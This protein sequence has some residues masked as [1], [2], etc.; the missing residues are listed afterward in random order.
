MRAPASSHDGALWPSVRA[1]ETAHIRASL[2]HFAPRDDPPMARRSGRP[3]S[4]TGGQKLAGSLG[5]G[6]IAKA[7]SDASLQS[8]SASHASAP[9]SKRPSRTSTR[10][11]DGTTTMIC[12]SWPCAENASRMRWSVI[13]ERVG[14]PAPVRRRQP[15]M[16]AVDVGVLRRPRRAREI[17][18][19]FRQHARAVPH[20]VAQIEIA[21]AREIAR[22]RPDQRAAVERPCGSNSTTGCMPMRIEQRLRSS[23]R[24]CG[25]G[26]RWRR[27]DRARSRASAR[28]R[29]RIVPAEL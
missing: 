14:R 21:E 26:D 25:C 9:P 17:D 15:P 22:R 18:P 7:P 27:A 4:R 20:A 8:P 23:T 16:R 5:R 24:A 6:P 13:S 28:R 19:A 1:H 12:P 11:F 3:G 29:C 2:E 10:S